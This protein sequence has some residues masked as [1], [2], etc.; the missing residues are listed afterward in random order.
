MLP[1]IVLTARVRKWLGGAAATAICC[2]GV[3]LLT[4][5]L[6]HHYPVKEW[7]VWRL[8][9]V[10]GYTLLLNAACVAFGAFALRRLL[11]SREL[12]ALE[13]LLQSMM[14]GF[15][16]FVLA[17]YLVGFSRLLKPSMAVLLPV[18]FLVVGF[19]DGRA[20]L[21]ELLAWRASIAQPKPT[22]RVLGALAIAGGVTALAFLYL[23]ALNVSVI[24]FDAT[25]YHFPI[26]QDYAREGRILAFPGENHRAY[27]HLTSMV[28]TWA[29][30]VPGL[31]RL[32]L[33]WM[34]SLHVEY[35][36]VVW[37]MVGAAALARWLLDGRD[38]RGL[39]A[40]FFLFPSVFVY[41]QA[42]G[43]SA[44]HFLGFFAAPI[45]LAGA[46]ALKS[47]D[48]R[49]GILLGVGLG[50]HL[51]VKYQ[52][53][54]LFAALVVA[55]AV[56]LAFLAGRR[57]LRARRAQLG[58][59]DPTFRALLVGVSCIALTT[60]VVSA[61]H[62]A[63]NAVYYHNPLY[64]FA[65][66]VFKSSY[67]KHEPGY[68]TEKAID[69]AFD[70]KLSG[71]RRQVWAARQIFEYAFE[72]SNRNLTNH[73]PYMGALFSLLL[74]CALLVAQRRRLFFV[75]GI[76]G[77]AFLVWAN[78]AANDRY[79]LGFYDLCIASTLALIVRV[80]DFGWPGW[81]GLTPLVGLQLV[82]GGD[83]MFFYGRK[84]LD[85]G[86]ELIAAGY[87][88]RQDDDRLAAKGAQQ[89]V[90][91]A[92][93]KNAVILARNYKGLLG[94]N[95]TVLSDIRTAQDYISYSHL[96]DPRDLYQLLE[97]R[98]VTHL[99]YPRGERRPERW[100]NT[101]LF[102]ELFLRHGV[103]QQRFG[104]LS[105]AELPPVAPPASVPY[106]V[107][108][109][110]VRGFPDGIYDVQ[111]LDVDLRFPSLFSPSPS[112]LHRLTDPDLP[113]LLADVRA[114]VSSHRKLSR[115]LSA[116]QLH[117]FELVESWDADEL[118]LRR[119]GAAAP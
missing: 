113:Q 2:V 45:A 118:H 98:G 57:V 110:G 16:C 100:N 92:T 75:I 59:D 71:L 80:W 89:Q 101:I 70:P 68:Y 91:R 11:G 39:W 69:G 54:F 79:L 88:G 10:W 29:L 13:R 44:D 81:V 35:S 36:I 112:P 84:E 87:S 6:D 90:T 103:H 73:R 62:F 119:V 5:N 74:P 55:I 30:L 96:K 7:L 14:L 3:F 108:V 94:L 43:G 47:F 58:A 40:G 102:T 106:L 19:N 1:Q 26:A 104:R 20:L 4:R 60:I 64:P 32:P 17:L 51:L 49:W 83:A 85:S 18:V 65:Q 109:S 115:T 116:E 77:V 107:L 31:S 12:P 22:E 9:P 33:H 99:L 52:G 114:L 78:A 42:I 48:V 86:L 37:R 41:D 56:R 23:E 38:V 93:P 27:P 28:H 95:R 50:A 8:A 82:W 21:S 25:W 66:S 111:Q 34:L 76:A 97:R 15:A 63:K 105:L 24:N 46:R 53:L 117:G 67:P 72:T 61:P